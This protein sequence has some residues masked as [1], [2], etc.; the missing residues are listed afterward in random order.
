MVGNDTATADED[1]P[2]TI[3]VLAN[4]TD[5]DGDPLSVTTASAGNGTVTVN[6]DG[7]LT[8]TPNADFHGTDTITYTVSDGQGGITTA[9]V[10]VTVNPV[11]DAPVGRGDAFT[12]GGGSVTIDLL[13]NDTDVDGDPLT[14]VAIDGQPVV[15]GRPVVLT[16]GSGTVTLNPDGTVTFTPAPG[17]SGQVSFSYTLF[18]GTTTTA[19]SVT[20]T[21]LAVGDP[22]APGNDPAQPVAARPSASPVAATAT[23]PPDVDT[24]PALWHQLA[25]PPTWFVNTPDSWT[26]AGAADL[27]G[28]ER[29]L[30]ILPTL[31]RLR[32]EGGFASGLDQLADRFDQFALR[33]DTS[34][35]ILPEA[36]SIAREAQQIREQADLMVPNAYTGTALDPDLLDP[37]TAEP[38]A[39]GPADEAAADGNQ[40]ADIPAEAMPARPVARVP[41]AAQLRQ[42]ANERTA[43]LAGRFFL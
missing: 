6:P 14:V 17:Y 1:T 23:A 10:T 35:H 24:P 32:M 29:Q 19:A 12:V 4:D 16:D 42:A 25:G 22:P 20:G 36:R 7:T 38:T 11:N 37:M 8:Y 27:L 34:L 5:V 13:T 41:F 31:E 43:L 3:D 30:F 2:V 40:P 28:F 26:D 9:T 39:D 18:D 15:V 21:V 33:L